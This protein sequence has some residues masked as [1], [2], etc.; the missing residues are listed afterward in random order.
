[1]HFALCESSRVYVKDLDAAEKP[2]R[3]EMMY[4]HSLPGKGSRLLSLAL[5]AAFMLLLAGCD[6]TAP[7][8]EDP[9]DR[10]LGTFE[11]EVTGAV[12]TSLEGVAAFTYTT[13]ETGEAFGLVLAAT[14]PDGITLFR[15]KAGRPATGIYSVTSIPALLEEDFW[16]G[17]TLMQHGGFFMSE[18]GTLTISSSSSGNLEGTLEFEASDGDGQQITVSA[19]FRAQCGSPDESNCE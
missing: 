2:P 8:E 12:T 5:L 15:Q 9:E 18:S 3:V 13:D 10:A 19:S 7:D 16:G 14:G 11:A 4:R 17:I 6:T 1:M